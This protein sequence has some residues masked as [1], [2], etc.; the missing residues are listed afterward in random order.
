M[1]R[2]TILAVWAA[3]ARLQLD[4]VDTGLQLAVLC[5]CACRVGDGSR[6]SVRD[7]LAA[8]AAGRGERSGP[9]GGGIVRRAAHSMQWS[10]AAA[11][12]CL[13]RRGD[14]SEPRVPSAGSA[15]RIASGFSRL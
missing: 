12:R 13:Q 2:R 10:N 7:G 14:N 15:H 11:R 6:T 9:C 1:R 5:K 8:A 4:C 3:G